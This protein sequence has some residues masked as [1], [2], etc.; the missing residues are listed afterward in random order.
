MKVTAAQLVVYLATACLSMLV[1]WQHCGNKVTDMHDGSSSTRSSGLKSLRALTNTN[2]HHDST[3]NA[4]SPEHRNRN[5]DGGT[6]GL[7]PIGREPL[8][9]YTI[10][11]R[12]ELAEVSYM[13]HSAQ[14]YQG[15]DVLW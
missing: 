15:Q 11:A 13:V 14:K 5:L 6:N 9:Q 8:E 10:Q 12:S 2:K 1:A 3:K 7:C 4:T